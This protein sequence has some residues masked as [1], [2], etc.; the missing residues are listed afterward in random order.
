MA[1]TTAGTA[2]KAPTSSKSVATAGA[3]TRKK[4]GAS[5]PGL[6][7]AGALPRSATR[8]KFT[9]FNLLGQPRAYYLVEPIDVPR[10][11]ADPKKKTVAHSII[12][13][14][15][16]GSMYSAMADTRD[17]LLKLLTLDEY[18]QFDLVVTLI[19]Y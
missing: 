13:V 3:P 18:A 6:A 11:P 16:S 2:R 10:P 4:A 19:S 8:T 9:L 15:R 5:A 7:P 12:V 14:D 17:T 1:K